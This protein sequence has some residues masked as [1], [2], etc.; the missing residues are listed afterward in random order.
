MHLRG[1]ATPPGGGG[2][3]RI[4]EDE[5]PAANLAPRWRLPCGPRSEGVPLTRRPPPRP[6]PA[7]SYISHSRVW[8]TGDT[9]QLN[10]PMPVRL[11]VANPR[12]EQAR[13]QVAVA[14][15]P[16]IYCLESVDLPESVTVDQIRLPRH[17]E[18]SV[19]YDAD[20]L[21]GV[22]ILETEALA[23]SELAL[24]GPL[25]REL[26]AEDPQPVTVR[27]IPYFAWNNRGE[28][29]MAVWLPSY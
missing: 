9:L 12:V 28:P 24:D 17:A 3:P 15:G 8:K 16:I 26:P 10:L 2:L 27:L 4:W 6:P 14:R 29:Q 7:G 13:G 21:G 18:W 22:S 11:I 5:A 20:L 25:Y 1:D 23:V 19:R